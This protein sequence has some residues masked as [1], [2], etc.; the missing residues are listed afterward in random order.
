[1]L[2]LREAMPE[3][4]RLELQFRVQETE[5]KLGFE[6]S[7]EHLASLEH[8]KVI[9]WTGNATRSRVEAAE[10]AVR[11][12]VSM[13]PGRPTLDLGFWPPTWDKDK[14]DDSQQV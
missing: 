14:R 3:L 1:M 6:F 4:R 12:A 11:G 7:F 13:H 9:I 8:I 2:F 5:S 10:A